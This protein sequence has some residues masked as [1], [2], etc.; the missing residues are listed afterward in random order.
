MA[1]RTQ[2]SSVA[3]TAPRRRPRNRK[4]QIAVAAARAFSERGYHPV[5]VDEIAAELGISGPAI[6]RHF[7]N[8]YALL[9]AA[10]DAEAA[11]L[12]NAVDDVADESLSPAEQLDAV[13]ESLVRAT[14]EHRRAGGLYRWER[15]YLE[16]ADRARVRE[17]LDHVGRA[18]ADPL[19]KLR[20]TTPAD[21]IAMHASAALSV[22][23]SITAHR[24]ALAADQLEPLLASMSTAVLGCELPPAPDAPPPARS[25]D[26]GLAVTSRRERVLNEAIKIFAARGY[27]E[28]SIEDI[29]TAASINASSVYR[30]FPSKADLLAA[31]FYRTADR[32][33]AALSDALAE[34]VDAVDA[35]R[36]ISQKYLALAFSGPELLSVYFAEFGNL[37]AAEQSSLRAIQRQNIEE[38]VHLLSE[39]APGTVSARFRVH[40]ALGLVLDIG[41]LIRFDP[42]PQSQV[43]VQTLMLHVLLGDAEIPIEARSAT[44][45]AATNTPAT[46]TTATPKEPA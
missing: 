36:R 13:I 6:Y 35:L 22:I 11:A 15:R 42:R 29:A 28:A 27:H 38:W 43:R 7:P 4:A 14:I 8:K 9:V 34:S 21:D 12:S 32:V 46:N 33:T 44:N 40:A 10:A 18:I 1:D 20:P 25:G 26:R 23:G 17:T 5:G 3:E 24:T 2:I 31:A 45:T 30:Y 41:R 39:L 37:P 19:S 16:P